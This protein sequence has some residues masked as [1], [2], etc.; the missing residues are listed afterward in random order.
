[1][2]KRAIVASIVLFSPC[3]AF[4]QATVLQGG[5]WT[6]GHVP[7]YS[8]SG[9]ST[10]IV[11]DGGTA[12]GGVVGT[13]PSEIGITGRGTGTA[14]YV[15]SGGGVLGAR[16]CMRDGPTSG[17]YHYLC[18]DPNMTGGFGGITFDAAGG[19]SQI[20]FKFIINGTTV[21]FTD[22][23]TI[24]VTVPNGGTGLTDFTA[25]NLLIGNGTSAATLLAPGTTGQALISQGA[26]ADPAYGAV[27]VPAG[28][29]GLGAITAHNLMIGNG[30]SAVSLLAPAATSGVPVVSQGSSADPVY[31]T[32]S[33]E[34]GGTGT[35]SFTANGVLY[36]NGTSAI[37]VTSTGASGQPLLSQGAGS[38]PAYGTVGIAAGGTGQTTANDAFN[39]LVPSQATHNGQFLTTDGT[40]TSWGTVAG[41]GTVTSVATGAGLTGGP[42]TISG[43][44][45]LDSIADNSILANISGGP[46]APSANTVSDILDSAVSS[47]Q[48]SILYRNGS[49]W[50]SL[51]PST[52]G[53]ALV[54][55]GAGANPS[56]SQYLI[57]NLAIAGQAQGD[58]AYFDGATWTRLPAGTNGYYLQTQGAGA[59]PT[60]AAVNTTPPVIHTQTFTT[61]GTFTFPVGTTSSTA[62]KF[63]ITGGGGSGGTNSSNVSGGGGGGAGATAIKTLTGVTAGNTV[64]VT[65]GAA[66]GSSSISSGTETITTVTGANGANGSN[67][68]GAGQGGLG[69]A[70]G[71][72]TNGDVNITGGNGSSGS[73]GI[74]ATLFAN[75][76]GGGASFYGGG[77]GD[78]A[79][80][81]VGRD[82]Q[83]YGSGGSGGGGSSALG[84]NNGGTGAPGIVTVEWV[85]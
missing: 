66:G 65:V 33:V 19:A 2:L 54:T 82:G 73:Q 42:I 48:G 5:P 14:P 80:D 75:G 69:G 20:P 7:Q 85:L 11:T 63:R 34:G 39:A 77:G 24:P 38:A 21:D 46:A 37:G 71:S 44:I 6:S 3:A 29:T 32:A 50:T 8:T 23:P 16:F 52:N 55:G 13:N 25:H 70:G 53:F 79:Y 76:G 57:N 64:T 41:T 40:N 43:T 68:A 84:N 72:A 36:G 18:I 27:G 17:A 22:F 81:Q 61:S 15:G 56:W 28:G 26:S 9:G 1:M 4:A 45:A 51:S 10:P 62:F 83:A 12:G 74:S 78:S 35:T 30:T 59:N 47:T 60:W 49:A 67:S 31:G 58:I